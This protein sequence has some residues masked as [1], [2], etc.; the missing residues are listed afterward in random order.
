MREFDVVVIGAGVA[1]EVAAGRLAENGSRGRDRRGQARRRR[2]LVLRLHAVEGAPPSGRARARG[3]RVPG[4]E[5]GPIDVAGRLARRDEV[6]LP[7]STTPVSCRGSRSAA[8]HWCAAAAAWTA[9][10]GSSSGAEHLAARKAVIVATG[11]RALDPGHRRPARGATL[12]EHRGHDR[13]RGSRS[14]SSILGGGVVGVELGQ[15]W[16]AFGA[17]VTLVHRGERLIEREE[18]FASAQVLGHCV[19]TA[20]TSGSDARRCASRD[21]APS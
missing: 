14:G 9:S 11:S 7:I 16:S 19:R 12:D 8:S 10:A 20:S 21:P 15:A 1:G 18:P 6:D 5:L 4:L 3:R 17:Q 2:V 13:N